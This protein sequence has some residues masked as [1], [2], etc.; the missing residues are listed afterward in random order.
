MEIS[1]GSEGRLPR[2]SELVHFGP[3]GALSTVT[4]G[5][6]LDAPLQSPDLRRQLAI[7]RVAQKGV[8]AA[9]VFDRTD[10]CRGNSQPN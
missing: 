7:G 1:G 4:F 10:P 6:P 2:A 9:L 3:E 5:S 8:D